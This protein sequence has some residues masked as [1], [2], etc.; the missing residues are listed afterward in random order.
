MNIN[1]KLARKIARRRRLGSPTARLKLTLF[2]FLS[3]VFLSSNQEAEKKKKNTNSNQTRLNFRRRDAF[4]APSSGWE[5][6]ALASHLRGGATVP[7][8]AKFRS[9]VP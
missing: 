7:S 6:K 2:P 5:T 3:G 9:K 1:Q 4:V 8:P